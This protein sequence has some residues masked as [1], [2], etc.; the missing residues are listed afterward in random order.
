MLRPNFLTTV[1]LSL[2]ALTSVGIRS[3]QGQATATGIAVVS[4]GSE[5]MVISGETS[6]PTGFNFAGFGG[7]PG[8]INITPFL[9]PN[10]PTSA[11]DPLVPRSLRVLSIDP[12]LVVPIPNATPAAT[13]AQQILSLDVNT[14]LSDIVTLIRS[15]KGLDD[16]V[17]Q[18]NALG[19]V[20]YS[21]GTFLQSI[22]GEVILQAGY[23]LGPLTIEQYEGLPGQPNTANYPIGNGLISSINISPGP[24][25]FSGVQ[26]TPNTVSAAAAIKLAEANGNISAQT[27]ILRAGPHLF[28][29]VGNNQSVATGTT[30]IVDIATGFSQSFSGEMALPNNLYFFGSDTGTYTEDPFNPPFGLCAPGS[31]CLFVAAIADSTFSGGVPQLQQLIV[32]PGPVAVINPPLNFNAQ[33]AETLANLDTVAALDEVV[34]FI[35]AGTTDSGPLSTNLQGRITGS[36]TIAIT[37]PA[38]LPPEQSQSVSGEVRL[39]PGLYFNRPAV[40]ASCRNAPGSCFAIAPDITQATAGNFQLDSIAINSLDLL[41][42]V[43]QPDSPVLGPGSPT[44]Y[45]FSAQVALKVY[46]AT[47]AGNL[48]NLVSLIRAGA[49]PSPTSPAQAIASGSATTSFANGAV[50]TVS[51]EVSLP[52]GQF[53]T[54]STACN[55]ATTS[56]FRIDPTYTIAADGT[57]ASLTVDPGPGNT[58]I[59]QWTFE[60]S[61]AYAIS[62]Q[63]G[64]SDTVSVIRAA[65]GAGGLE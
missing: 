42:G 56:C 50:Q 45:D 35:R 30:S 51:G 7:V 41:P 64:V 65:V 26:A 5:F 11:P 9:N 60:G 29:S 13:V 37:R 57:L 28:D 44:V 53:F 1:A 32:D 52:T 22:T 17:T 40:D 33:A 48:S 4:S 43:T 47:A 58:T 63:T 10:P 16:T 15:S 23:F 20:T 27:S 46:E 12:G 36:A 61:K 34:S 59:E 62:Q 6:V 25:D 14:Q 55:T 2:L 19:T 24:A 49:S 21:N 18:A 3:A 8:A 39:P 31:S 54:G 38:P